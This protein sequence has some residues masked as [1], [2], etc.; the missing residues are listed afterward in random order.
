MKTSKFPEFTNPPITV[1][2][3][4]AELTEFLKIFAP[5]GAGLEAPISCKCKTGKCTSCVCTKNS[6]ACTDKCGCGV[7]C[8]NSSVCLP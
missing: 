6:A 5:F 7:N 1:S 8:K 2:Q 4:S 3:V